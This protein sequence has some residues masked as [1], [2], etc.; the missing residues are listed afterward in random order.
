MGVAQDFSQYKDQ[1]DMLP[2]SVRSA[3]IQRINSSDFNLPEIG[4]NDSIL[5]E[6]EGDDDQAKTSIEQADE[7]E[8]F[9][10]LQKDIDDRIKWK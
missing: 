5:L 2:D 6:D 8:K 10:L 3:V 9:D 4:G 7:L 1:L